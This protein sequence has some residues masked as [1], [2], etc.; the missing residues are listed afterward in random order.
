MSVHDRHGRASL[1]SPLTPTVRHPRRPPARTAR[2]DTSGPRRSAVTPRTVTLA[3]LLAALVPLVGVHTVSLYRTGDPGNR[4]VSYLAVSLLLLLS[5]LNRLWRRVRP[6]WALS[7]SELVTLYCVTALCATFCSY[8]FLF[9]LVGGMV[10][11]FR[12][13][14][15][16]NRWAALFHDRLPR[17]AMVEDATA[18]RAFYEGGA[19]LFAD[20]LYR[21]WLGP[22]LWWT[23]FL[24]ALVGAFLALDVLM[25]RRWM[26]EERL[27]FPLVEIPLALA[28]AEGE[29]SRSLFG[30]PWG[31]IGIG[32]AAGL[33]LWSRLAALYPILPPLPM[34]REVATW[35]GRPWSALGY[36]W[37]FWGP[38]TFGLA[39]LIPLELTLSLWVFSLFWA[40]ELI[41]ADTYW[42]TV[43]SNTFPYLL[44]QTT[45]AYL[46]VAALVL[47]SARRHLA[48]VGRWAL[49]LGPRALRT[50]SRLPTQHPTLNPQR[51]SPNAQHPTPNAPLREEVVAFWA[52]LVCVAALV[53]FAVGLGMRPDVA[54]TFV[55]L[56]LAFALTVTRLRAQVGVPFHDL[57]GVN[58]GTVLLTTRGAEGLRVG[59]MVGIAA[60]YFFNRTYR[61]TPMPPMLEG[62]YGATAAR[63]SARRLPL[64]FLGCALIAVTV[65]L[66]TNLALMSRWGAATAH[67]RQGNFIAGS[68]STTP[69]SRLATW[70]ETGP[71]AN[72]EATLAMTAGFA[73]SLG[74]AGI[75]GRF[76]G[77]PF[78]PVAFAISASID[79]TGYLI[80]LF[81]A[82]LVKLLVLRY[83]GLPLYRR[84]SQFA[85]GLIVGWAIV[86]TL[87]SLVL[88]PLLG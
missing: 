8:E 72:L 9:M 56:Y 55:L 82:W 69:W 21:A 59:D 28:A 47:W 13:A 46:G 73:A 49:G 42:A 35:P 88:G 58:P 52:L 33:H 24:M 87:F 68:Y 78:H 53:V 77:W 64:L 84:A 25:A 83:G 6:G 76:L 36:R 18:V 14:D 1:M 34:A 30:S 74:L 5:L 61:A 16:S 23:L 75:S 38:E 10:Y 44:A 81:T 41:V 39:F 15:G 85:I 51:S 19:A 66:W 12:F 54:L 27:A 60:F 63:G 45:G 32:L 7:P 2:A 40:T 37:V 67:V 26:A 22:V 43:Q 11:P 71:P 20:G 50:H 65:T 48:G 79:A 4:S 62:I 31:W 17:W 70:L 80:P 86:T 29:R 57:H 3:L